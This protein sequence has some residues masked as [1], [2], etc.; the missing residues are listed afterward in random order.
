MRLGIDASNIRAGGGLTHLVET[1]RVA[2]PIVHCFS[3][4]FVWGN[5]DTLDLIEDRP[6]LEKQHQPILDKGLPFRLLWQR[7]SLSDTARRVGCDII[8]V[9]GGSYAGDFHPVV[10]M[11]RNML[12][13]EWREARRYGLS[14]M[15]LK[16][17][18]LKIAQMRT[19]SR[20]DGVI[21][22]TQYARDVVMRSVE[23]VAGRVAVVPHGVGRRFF[24]PPREQ[25]SISQ[26]SN[27]RPLRVLYVS[28]VDVYKH[29]WHVAEAIAKL[30]SD[31]IP[32]VLDMV[33]ASRPNALVRLHKTLDRIDPSRQFVRLL[34]HVP[35]SDIQDCYGRSDICVFASSCE[36]MPNILVESMASGLPIACSCRG[37]MPEVLGDA[38][39]YFDPE[40]PCD[41]ARAIEVLIKSPDL[42][43][44][45]AALAYE[46]ASRL[47]WDRSVNDL[48]Y[49]LSDVRCSFSTC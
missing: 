39:V 7:F 19:F 10:A 25:R 26:C 8:L 14:S 30:R 27:D 46:R 32:V 34:G 38:G 5:A 24:K 1:L 40:K 49:F 13:F 42:R 47:T 9:P 2:D 3:R 4:I 48:F 22:L 28:I 37:P 12:P 29:Q 43:L 23:N 6:W 11:S 17:L 36:N 21:F 44:R 16:M 15:T 41:I 35:F 18:L 20:A 45:I 33:G 31:G